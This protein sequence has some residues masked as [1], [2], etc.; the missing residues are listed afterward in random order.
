MERLANLRVNY[1][2]SKSTDKWVEYDLHDNRTRSLFDLEPGRMFWVKTRRNIPLHL[3]SGS[4]LS[5]KDTFSLD[6]P[7]QQW[8]DFG[9]P[10]R[11]GVRIEEILTSSGTNAL[12]VL[13]YR[14]KRDSSSN[15]HSL[16]PLYVPGIP[17]KTDR[18]KAIEY[19]PRGGYSFYNS[20]TKSVTLRI[21]P[22]L[23]A[24]AK[25]LGK[26]TASDGSSWSARFSARSG[27]GAALPAVYFGYAPGIARSAYPVPPSFSTLRLSVFDRNSALRCGNHIDEDAADGLVSELLI[28]NGADTAQ[29]IHYHF[30]RTGAFPEDYNAFC[31]DAA[32]GR[33]DTNASITVAAKA[34]ASRWIVV[35]DA[36]FRER[37]I[38]SIS[39][40]RFSLHAP[41]PNPARSVVNI[42]YTV[43]F[44]SRERIAIA[45]YNVMGKRVWEKRIDDLLAEGNHVVVW[46]GRDTHGSP[47]G[48]GLYVIRL[49][50]SDSRGGI[51]KRFDQCVTLMR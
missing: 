29:T 33:I 49:S 10:Y 11:F 5:L 40:L 21:P 1:S 2:A 46:N 37:F 6:L 4:T 7:P 47:V 43:P 18:S 41:Y 15:V 19:L 36:P 50:V 35:G 8:T 13:F 44:G 14:W 31:F 17:D 32:A 12:S 51:L 34:A 38:A 16:E 23:A 24:M 22:V 45:V 30:E 25:Q 39:P 48:S 42:R 27:D 28:D 9:M 20:S 3:D 26:R